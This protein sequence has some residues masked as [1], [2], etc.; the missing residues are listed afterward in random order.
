[1][2][3]FVSNA[4]Y[5]VGSS[6]SSV[7][8]FTNVDGKVDV[9]SANSGTNTLTMLTNNGSGGF[10]T[11]ATLVVGHAPVWVVAADVNGDGKVDLVCAN[12]SD[13]TLTV[14]T[15]NG[16][17]GFG[18]NATYTVGS[19]P[20]WVAAT[21][22]NGDGKVDLISAN[23]GTNTLTVLTNNGSGWLRFQCHAGRGQH[24]VFGHG[25]G[26]QRGWQGGFDFRQLWHQLAHGFDQ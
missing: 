18:S 2:A 22:V 13:N 11:A 20:R 16:S 8:A 14:L 3:Y 24:A 9:V 21:D 10:A 26:C 5:T 19:E 1:M 12:F 17:G 15:N 7:A 23:Y 4:A 25:G 6:P